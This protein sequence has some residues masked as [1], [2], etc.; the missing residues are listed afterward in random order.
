M[1]SIAE[2]L[3]QWTLVGPWPEWPS[4]E[5]WKPLPLDATTALPASAGALGEGVAIRQVA[6]VDGKLNLREQL[7]GTPG[8]QSQGYA[9]VELNVPENGRL[10]LAFDADYWMMWWLDGREI[11]ATRGLSLIHI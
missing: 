7:G 11:G 5:R 1:K 10:D 6:A 4:S 9:F 3:T 2:Q 8:T